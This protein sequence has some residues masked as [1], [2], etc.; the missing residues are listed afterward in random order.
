MT[1]T[2]QLSRLIR[3]RRKKLGLSLK[4]LKKESGV[5]V[6]LIQKYEKGGGNPTLSTLG[7]LGRVLGFKLYLK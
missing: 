2:R 6:S 4:G 3:T 7:A 5:S 1:P